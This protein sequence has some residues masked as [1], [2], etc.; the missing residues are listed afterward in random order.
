[1]RHNHKWSGRAR[2]AAHTLTRPELECVL[3]PLEACFDSPDGGVTVKAGTSLSFAFSVA[4]SPCCDGETS[5][6]MCPLLLEGENL[7]TRFFMLPDRERLVVFVSDAF[8]SAFQFFFSPST[9][10]LVTATCPFECVSVFFELHMSLLSVSWETHQ[11]TFQDKF[12]TDCPVFFVLTNILNKVFH[13][14]ME[15]CHHTWLI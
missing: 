15:N 14:E 5:G 7:W 8:I 1:M 2:Q 6:A 12:K 9:S 3:G 4:F 11:S 10:L 13:E